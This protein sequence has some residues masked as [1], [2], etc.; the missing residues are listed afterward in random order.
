[1]FLLKDRILKIMFKRNLVFIMFL[2]CLLLGQSDSIDLGWIHNS[3]DYE[4]ALR[5][6][7]ASNL[8]SEGIFEPSKYVVKIIAG[9]DKLEQLKNVPIEEWE[10]ML[11]DES[12][13][14]A[15]NLILYSLFEKDAYKLVDVTYEEWVILDRK[16]EINEWLEFLGN[17]KKK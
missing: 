12:T 1:M 8:F 4:L 10:I 2:P 15:T 14:F 6:G 17:I 13:D 5:R 16:R 7:N 11:N 9:K 3:I